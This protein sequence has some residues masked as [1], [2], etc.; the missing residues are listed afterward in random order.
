M[1]TP[2]RAGLRPAHFWVSDAGPRGDRQ[3]VANRVLLE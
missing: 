1:V 3:Q 2:L